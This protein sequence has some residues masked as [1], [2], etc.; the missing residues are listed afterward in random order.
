[1]RRISEHRGTTSP[2]SSSPSS[3]NRSSTNRSSP[4]SWCSVAVTVITV[5][6]VIILRTVQTQDAAVRLQDSVLTLQQ[7]STD[8]LDTTV[9]TNSVTSTV[10]PKYQ[11]AFEQSL[12][13]FD[14]IPNDLWTGYYQTRARKAEHYREP[15]RPN[16]GLSRTTHWA[17]FNWDP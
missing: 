6:T 4:S 7:A 17:F 9:A 3:T 10:A 2:L 11:L 16:K 8:I 13:F 15:K 5:A 14:D 12:G 1:M